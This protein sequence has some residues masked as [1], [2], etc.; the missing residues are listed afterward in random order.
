[1]ANLVCKACNLQKP[2]PKCPKC[3]DD[4]A[5]VELA[6]AGEKGACGNCGLTQALPKHCGWDM[7]I[8]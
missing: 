8:A 4:D 7:A 1:M 3:S 5:V 6:M 2:A